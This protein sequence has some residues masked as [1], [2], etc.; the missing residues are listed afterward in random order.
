MPVSP[1]PSAEPLV[2]RR[3]ALG[4]FADALGGDGFAF[5]SLVGD[6]GSGKS[7]LLQELA[8]AAQSAG[9]LT[10]WGRAAEFDEEMPFGAVV[11]ALDDHL[12]NAP[13]VPRRL[14]P[15]AVRLLGTVF[16]A[17]EDAA[18]ES[19]GAG[20]RYRLHKA[21][22]QLLD[23]LARDDGLV[24]ILDDLHWADHATVELLDHLVRHPPR[25]RVLV[26]LAYRPVQAMPRLGALAEYG[27]QINVGPLSLDEVAELLGP[28]IGRERCARLYQASGGNPF[29][30]D[31]L[32]RSEQEEGEASEADELPRAVRSALQ[33]EIS[34]LTAG[35]QVAAQGAAVAAEEFDPVLVA[36]AALVAVVV[37]AP[38]WFAFS[39]DGG[40]GGTGGGA[41]DGFPA[42]YAGSWD[43]S[44]RATGGQYGSVTYT[45]K[46]D[47]FKGTTS[48]EANLES[49]KGLCT[50]TMNLASVKSDR[51]ELDMAGQAGCP[52][53]AVRLTLQGGSL[54]M[55]LTAPGPITGDGLLKKA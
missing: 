11:D 50:A 31:A 39:G 20:G 13:E 51:I 35:A 22:K 28:E 33:L 32:A 54:A 34:R 37:G 45:V 25:G 23:E 24:L 47:L 43:G 1:P 2:G 15:T 6:P 18:A 17:L 8:A 12:E 52:S 10:L 53:G 55:H 26:A 27:E 19:T 21:A 41:S 49:T 16:P 36:V 38:A 44:V 3:E 42:A 48:T 29:Y 7:R 30:L 5:L 40:G 9:R 14:G 4:T 46:F